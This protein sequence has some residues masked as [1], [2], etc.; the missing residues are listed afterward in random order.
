[1]L[2]TGTPSANCPVTL[3]S[4]G[5]SVRT[6]PATDFGIAADGMVGMYGTEKLWTLLPTNGIWR[7]P[8]PSKPDDFAYDNKLPWFRV[9]S[10][11]R[12]RP[13]TITGERLDGP[14]PSFTE[15]YES[16]AFPD[17][18]V[19]M[20]GISILFSV[21]GRSQDTTLRIGTKLHGLGLPLPGGKS[22]SGR[23]SPPVSQKP[24]VPET[25]PRR[26][27]VDSEVR[28][29]SLVYSVT[30]EIPH[31]AQVA[32][33]LDEPTYVRAARDGA[34]EKCCIRSARYDG[35]RRSYF[36]PRIET[37]NLAWGDI[38]PCRRT[39]GMTYVLKIRTHFCE[40]GK[41]MNVAIMPWMFAAT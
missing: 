11:G 27:H 5:S 8:I 29:R 19:I 1:V 16:S 37:V 23:S 31:E 10:S 32:R 35:S 28:E 21:V 26:I 13:L 20:G 4:E 14:A 34:F 33:S 17:G 22:S 3:P 12:D 25:A 9:P 6:S 40:A 39:S 36:F 15:T 7:G 30:P 41:S 38:A 2:T 24:S 18:A